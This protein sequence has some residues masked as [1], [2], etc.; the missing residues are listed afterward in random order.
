MFEERERER[1]RGAARLYTQGECKPE[2]NRDFPSL[3]TMS[4]ISMSEETRPPP[5]S[6]KWV[7]CK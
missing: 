6:V 3:Q 1:V 2:E 5:G 7:V 4:V